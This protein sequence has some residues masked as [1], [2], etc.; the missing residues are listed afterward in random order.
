M[1]PDQAIGPAWQVKLPHHRLRTLAT[2]LASIHRLSPSPPSYT[3]P[4]TVVCISD[5]HSTQPSLP[6]GD[7]FLHA[8]D[9]TQWGTYTKLQAQVTWLSQQPHTYEVVIAGNHDLLLDGDFIQKQPERW[10]QA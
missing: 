5:T 9:L 7:L 10:R 2:K 6:G 1:P 3:S 4:I 8:G